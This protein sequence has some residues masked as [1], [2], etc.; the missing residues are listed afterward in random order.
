MSTTRRYNLEDSHLLMTYLF[1][2]RISDVAKLQIFE[3]MVSELKKPYVIKW[4]SQVW[5]GKVM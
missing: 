5:D 3:G 2:L 1:V 4:S